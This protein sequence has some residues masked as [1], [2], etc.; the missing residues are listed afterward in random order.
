MVFITC[1]TEEIAYISLVAPNA[2]EMCLRHGLDALESV[3][4]S[5]PFVISTIL[6]FIDVNLTVIGKVE[7]LT[8]LA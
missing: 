1:V 8:V 7:D 4:Q 6:H 3:A 5:H 2:R